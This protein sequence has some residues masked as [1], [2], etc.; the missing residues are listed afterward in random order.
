MADKKNNL[1]NDYTPLLRTLLARLDV[2][3]LAADQA[4]QPKIDARR[5]IVRADLHDRAVGLTTRFEITPAVGFL[6][7]YGLIAH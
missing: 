3:Y 4:T 7:R 5:S 6:Y 2:A 1:G